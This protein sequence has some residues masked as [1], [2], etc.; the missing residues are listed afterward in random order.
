VDPDRWLVTFH[1]QMFLRRVG[2]DP[3]VNGDLAPYYIDPRMAGCQVLLQ[4]E[5]QGAQFV[6]WHAEEAHQ[7]AANQGTDGARDGH[8]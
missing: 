8:R 2:R 6:V 1:H 3:R 7:E 4:V 5:A